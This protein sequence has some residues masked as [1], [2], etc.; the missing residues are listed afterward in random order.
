MASPSADQLPYFGP[1]LDHTED[2]IV[3]CDADW[4]VT[5]WNEGAR[6]M[7]GWSADEALGRDETFFRLDGTD[8]RRTDRRRQLAEYGRWRGE[9]MVRRKDGSK[10]PVE[11]ISVALRDEQGGMSGYLGIHRDITDRKRAEEA[12]R[13]A[14]RRT[15]AILERISDTFFAVD[16]QWRYTYVNGRAVGRAREAWGRDASAEELLGKNC[17][18]LFPEHLGTT[19]DRELHRAVR[20]QRVVEF[21]T[22]SA[23]NDTW[24]EMRAYPSRDGL[25]VYSRDVTAR[26]RGREALAYHASL[27]DNVEDGVIATHADD[28]SIS[29]WNKGAE[30]LYGFTAEEVLGRPAREV[31]SSPGDPARHKL[32]HE[33]LTTGRTR[34]EFTARRKDGTPIEIELV[35]AEVRD[36]RGEPIGYLG[37]HRD[38]T[39]RRRA[40]GALRE[41]NRRIES[42]LQSISDSFFAVD[43]DWRYTYLN[44]R[45]VDQISS[46]VGRYVTAGQLLGRSCWETFPEWEGTSV[47]QAYELALREKRA[48]EVDVYVK[49][50]A[51][52]FEA[53]LYPSADGVSTYLRDITER[54]Q[55]EEKLAYHAQLLENLNDAVL[56][57][58]E[59]LV[60]TAWNKAA[61]RMFGWTT[62]EAVGQLMYELLPSSLSQEELAAE[63][64]SLAETGHRRTEATWFGKDG[65]PVFAESSNVALRSEAGLVMGYLGIMRDL[66]ERQRARK[67][68]EMRARQQALLAELTLR[69]LASS[70]LQALLDDAVTLVAGML[71]VELSSI[72][73]ILPGGR[74]MRWRAAFGWDQEAVTKAA[75]SPATSES[76]VGYAFTTGGPVISED[77]RN[78][79]RFQISELFAQQ[80]PASAIAVVIPVVK[81]R[82]GALVAASRADRLFTSADVD[83]VRA[84]ATIV[85]VAVERSQ[86]GERLEEVRENE[87]SR[88]ARDLHD[89]ALSEL[90]GAV[91]Q[92]SMAVSAS[93]SQGDRDRWNSQLAMLQRVGW[94]L[95]NSI[96]NLRLTGEEHRPFVDLLSELVAHHSE[97]T[98][99]CDVRLEGHDTLPTWSLGKNGSEILGIVGEAITNARRHSGARTVTVDASGSDAAALRLEVRD[100][101]TW[102]APT[103]PAVPGQ[104]TGI[105]SMTERA[106]LLGARLNIGADPGGGTV[107][108]VELK[109]ASSR[110][111]GR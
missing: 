31:A 46:A 56:A 7:Y 99:G 6:R 87:R 11:A 59:R 15:E 51:R 14:N 9:I 110:Q 77:V 17:W 44:Q 16:D 91:A 10:V 2:A 109:L 82:F 36:D 100:D 101:G 28:F 40:D 18:E 1:L 63:I 86:V 70:E 30:R 32:E 60:L 111:E 26:R 43:R 21:E 102:Q 54:K 73:E 88:I 47:A 85:G 58:D 12:L 68:L 79:S 108:A 103:A 107:V 92:A 8:E 65:T 13:A 55:A 24:V 71:E 49:S 104:G 19:F 76:L 93:A 69:N 72:A 57:T 38:I 41:A 5:V 27:L 22:Y 48:T 45:A 61:E 67:E 62:E 53:H 39:E 98:E 84:V 37:I 105:T 29:A 42:I 106:D 52:W 20:E 35:A 25:S 80:Q 33:L 74:E 90:A 23:P 81:E 89:D 97:M 4:R 50:S 34:I 3:A 94:Q 75:P 95:R 96:Y 64:A 66:S 83:F 78:D